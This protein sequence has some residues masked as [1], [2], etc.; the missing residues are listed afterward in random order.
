MN[1]IQNI[2]TYTQFYI[3]PSNIVTPIA[4]ATIN[5]L[6]YLEYTVNIL[7]IFVKTTS[8][9]LGELFTEFFINLSID[10]II[11]LIGLY[12]LIMLFIIDNDVITN[13]RNIKKNTCEIESIKQQLI[14]L[15]NINRLRDNED[16]ALFQDIKDNYNY[17]NNKFQTLDRKLKKIEKELER[18]N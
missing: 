1:A 12:N 15:R 4:T 7:I 2:T 16:S 3:S 9:I 5:L 18:Y 8:F 17:T 14:Y 13:A 11:Y 10:K 6:P